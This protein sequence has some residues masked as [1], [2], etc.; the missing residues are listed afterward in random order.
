MSLIPITEADLRSAM[1]DR[2]YWTSGHPERESYVARVTKGWYAPEE[3]PHRNAEGA[4]IVFVRA[5]TR[6]RDGHAE[7][8]SAHQRSAPPRSEGA[9]A[10]GA[11][12]WQGD[13]RAGSGGANPNRAGQ[14]RPTTI[15]PK[16]ARF[17]YEREAQA[18]VS[19]RPH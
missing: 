18:G 6:V 14:A 8:V 10:E 1:R 12:P 7:H 5:Y 13:G 11:A 3:S 15:S 16:G 19:D 9:D 2:R 4:S 17:L